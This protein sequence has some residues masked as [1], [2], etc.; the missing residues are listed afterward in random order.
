V[1]ADLTERPGLL[2]A[3]A[4][5]IQSTGGS[6]RESLAL[7]R[8]AVKLKPD[9]WVV[10]SNIQNTLMIL[11]Q[12]DEA[13]RAGEEIRT[14]AGGRP[15]RAPESYYVNWDYLTWNLRAWLDATVTNAETNAGGGTHVA[16]AGPIIADIQARLHDPEAAEFSLKTTKEDP[17]DPTIAAL[18]HFVRGW[19]AAESGD[20]GDVARAAT[21]MEAFGA[22]Y[23]NPFVSGNIPGYNCWIAPAEDAAGRP[24]QADA[25]LKSAG[26][27][28]DCYRFRAD[29]LDR[30]GDWASAQKAY[31][32]AV[33]L[34]P[35]L[36]A[37][38]F[39]WGVALAKH[40]DLDGAVAKLALANQRGPH[41]ADPLK[42]WGDVLVKQGNAKKAL[43]KY[44]EAMNYA[45]NWKELK[46][47]R[48]AIVKQK[49]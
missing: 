43:A 45:P 32:D 16:S 9:L 11:G 6:T 31:A 34:A 1:S 2:N 28:V 14:A 12:E 46:D 5:A 42:S 25:L 35:N 4:I 38:Y 15:G 8:A 49:S 22:A 47:A 24:D 41:W 18:S 37:A 27:F 13:W 33:A 10:H 7:L 3:W 20:V 23:S 19:L 26:T 40:G 39:S 48:D 36:P 17:H 44:D 30:R 21:E 29:I